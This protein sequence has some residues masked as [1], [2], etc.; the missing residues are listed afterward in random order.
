MKSL[1]TLSVAAITLA[2]C[3]D[4]TSPTSNL[5]AKDGKQS[6]PPFTVSGSLTNNTYTFDDGTFS[7]SDGGSFTVESTAGGFGASAPSLGAVYNNASNKFIGRLDNHRVNLIVPNGGSRYDISFDLYIIGSWDGNGKQSG[8]QYGVD[9]WEAAVACSPTGPAVQTLIRTT[10]SN[11]KTVQ[12]S[13]PHNYGEGGG[14]NKAADGAFAVD[15]LG[16][17]NDPTSHTPQFQ[18]Y[19]D[20]WYKMHFTGQNPC[21]AGAPLF[22]QWSVPGATLQSNYDESWGVDNVRIMTDA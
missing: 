1:I 19:G 6:D 13:Y 4:S 20:T 21:G 17:V 16:F 5:A 18:S 9:I 12:Q 14:S 8:K 11:Q 22:L 10:F 2:A 7:S 3:T 15:A